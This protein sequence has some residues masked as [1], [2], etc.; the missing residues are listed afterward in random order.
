MKNLIINIT[1]F[2]Y[3]F[4]RS[5]RYESDFCPIKTIIKQLNKTSINLHTCIISAVRFYYCTFFSGIKIKEIWSYSNNRTHTQCQITCNA[6]Q[7]WYYTTKQYFTIN[8]KQAF[9][10][11]LL[12]FRF[13]AIS[14]I[15]F[16]QQKS[17]PNAWKLVC[18]ITCLV[19][20]GSLGKP[21]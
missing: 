21:F 2:P 8:T 5:L 9:M 20:T 16:N 14:I 12:C 13:F 19:Y 17:H 10:R 7:D 6:Y 3:P 1:S 18:A 11:H 4:R 15:L